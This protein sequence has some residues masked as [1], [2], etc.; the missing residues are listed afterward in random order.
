MKAE[1][2]KATIKIW[3]SSLSTSRNFNNVTEIIQ[4]GNMALIKT[5]K[6]NQ[7]LVNMDNVNLIE[8]MEGQYEKYKSRAIQ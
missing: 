5:A 7:H 6:G 1:F 8:E 4:S 3:F 2:D